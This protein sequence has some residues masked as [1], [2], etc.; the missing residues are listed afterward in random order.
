ME[1]KAWK[2]LS[3]SNYLK[4]QKSKDSELLQV[5]NHSDI[6]KIENL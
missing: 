4:Y 1:V 2:F 3:T 6:E 5:I